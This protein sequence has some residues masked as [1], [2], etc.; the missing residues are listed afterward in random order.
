MVMQPDTVV[1]D[2][3][4]VLLDWDPRHM[5]R[6]IFDGRDAD[7]EWFLA[8]VCTSEWNILQDAGRPWDEATDLLIAAHP[9]HEA[10]GLKWL[11]GP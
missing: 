10:A 8:N 9:S 5:Y 11:P 4:G 6:K 3:G 2:I 1:F 7:M